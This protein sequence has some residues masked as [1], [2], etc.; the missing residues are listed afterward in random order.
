LSALLQFL[1]SPNLAKSFRRDITKALPV[2]QLVLQQIEAEVAPDGTVTRLTFSVHNVDQLWRSG[3]GR[4]NSAVAPDETTL[5]STVSTAVSGLLH[6]NG[7]LAVLRT[8]LLTS[9]GDLP[10][11]PNESSNTPRLFSNS[12]DLMPTEWA[13]PKELAD[14]INRII[15]NLSLGRAL[16][17][18]EA[19]TNRT[20]NHRPSFRVTN[21]HSYT[22]F[23]YNPET[24]AV[25]T[26]EEFANQLLKLKDAK[27]LQ[28]FFSLWK[29]ASQ[30]D[31]ST[32]T[33]VSISELMGLC[34]KTNG[35]NKFNTQDR[36]E[37]S[38][39]LNYLASITI[40]ETIVGERVNKRTG[41]SKLE[42]REEKNVRLFRMEA[43]YSIKK[44]FRGL[45]KSELDPEVH[46]DKTVITRFSGTLLPNQP[47]LF[48]QRASIFF[49]N[50]LHLDANKDGKAIVVGFH[51]QTRFNQL[52]DKAKPIEESRDF[53]IHLCDYQQ[54]NQTKPSQATKQLRNNFDKLINV[55][56]ISSYS[57]L[58]N[59]NTDRIKLMPPQ[60]RLLR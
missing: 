49:D 17:Q 43:T 13:M 44:E 19:V 36:R 46:V 11:A 20:R 34:L 25:N 50:L 39:I 28:V 29:W 48:T 42:I 12:K 6:T 54:T 21:Q 56:I 37:F 18:Y 47:R 60:T 7:V 27:V 52:M 35:E 22:E 58:T 55:G 10:V 3:L 2:L 45:P 57:G 14:N 15:K 4:V 23:V 31:A 38:A 53:L 32:F 8:I 40:T 9:Q 51:L 59:T 24:V 5:L 33:D 16:D 1:A 41:T 30:H 26:A